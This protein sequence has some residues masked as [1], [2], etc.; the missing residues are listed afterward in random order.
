MEAKNRA[1]KKWKIML[2][3]QLVLATSLTGFILVKRHQAKTALEAYRKELI[4]QGEQLDQAT[5]RPEPTEEQRARWRVL[6]AAVHAAADLDIRRPPAVILLKHRPDLPENDYARE[7]YSEASLT[8]L[9]NKFDQMAESYARLLTALDAGPLAFDLDN[10]RQH[11]IASQ[12]TSLISARLALSFNQDDREAAV[13]DCLALL[14]I[15][16]SSSRSQF[17]TRTHFYD[18]WESTRSVVVE[19]TAAD[20]FE[21]SDF[22]AIQAGLL[23]A[24]LMNPI[25]DLTRHVRGSVIDR[26]RR[27]AANRV[28]F[29]Q[30]F[31]P[32]PILSRPSAIQD[33]PK[34]L[35]L[36]WQGII[37]RLDYLLSREQFLIYKKFETELRTLRNFQLQ[38]D[39]LEEVTHNA[40]ILPTAKGLFQ[41]N[42]F[43]SETGMLLHL[44]GE[45]R[46]PFYQSRLTIETERRLMLVAIALERY[47]LVNGRHPDSLQQLTPD[48]LEHPI[49]DPWTGDPLNYRKHADGTFTLYSVGPDGHDNGGAVYVNLQP[50]RTDEAWNPFSHGNRDIVWWQLPAAADTEMPEKSNSPA[51]VKGN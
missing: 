26:I 18:S 29:E 8:E 19:A 30:V 21:E 44:N 20:W 40:P 13:S 31:A 48:F 45:S 32:P 33:I 3:V 7:W 50:R 39:L 5:F 28:A 34:S 23:K 9:R 17:P 43:E 42:G 15:L 51:S 47:R 12:A 24:D 6:E 14:S 16:H 37:R 4:A 10:A 1:V 46:F 2:V 35:L 25:S 41:S 38:I 22:A 27:P 49:G 36:T 11:Q